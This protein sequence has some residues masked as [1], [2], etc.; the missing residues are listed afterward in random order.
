VQ[1]GGPATA[2]LAW[3]PVFTAWCRANGAPYDF[4]SSHLYPTDPQLPLGRDNFMEAV[5][6]ASAQAAAAGVPFMLTEFN[7]G[8]GSPE[9]NNGYSMLDSSFAAAF[10]LHQHLLAQ[11]VPNLASM[12]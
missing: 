7:A 11:A 10:L 2:M 1:V 5:A 8:L 9:D 3:V 6:N 12:S 4:V